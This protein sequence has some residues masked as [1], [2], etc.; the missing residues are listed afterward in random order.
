MEDAP[1][2]KTQD[3]SSAKTGASYY[4]ADYFDWQRNI[5]EFGGWANAF[6]FKDSI[7]ERDVVVDFGCGGGFLLNNLECKRRIGIEPNPS[8]AEYVKNFGIKHFNSPADA[9]NELGVGLPT[10]TVQRRRRTLQSME[11]TT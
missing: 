3:D 7:T 8:A 5:G 1:H 10:S 2:S 11:S 9:V 6:K 4:D